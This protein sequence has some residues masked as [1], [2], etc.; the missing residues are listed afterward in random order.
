MDV[1]HSF[2]GGT[3]TSNPEGYVYLL[4]SDELKGDFKIV[5]QVPGQKKGKMMLDT[6]T[7][8]PHP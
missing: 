6:A 8:T 7:P 2:G 4:I 3:P 1:S 5:I